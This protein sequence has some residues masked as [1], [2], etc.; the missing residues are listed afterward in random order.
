MGLLDFRMYIMTESL[1]NFSR[2]TLNKLIKSGL[3]IIQ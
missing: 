2:Y 3:V 1:E